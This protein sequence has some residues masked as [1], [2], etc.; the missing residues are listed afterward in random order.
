MILTKLCSICL[1][2]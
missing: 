2:L 1:F